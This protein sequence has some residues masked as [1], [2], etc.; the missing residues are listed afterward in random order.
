[1]DTPHRVRLRFVPVASFT[2]VM[3]L[4]GLSLAWTAAEATLGMRADVG[5]PLLYFATAVFVALLG[6]YAGKSALHPRRVADEFR[7]PASMSLFP[8]ISIGFILIAAGFA[9][10]HPEAA[11]VLWLGGAALHLGLTLFAVASWIDHHVYAVTQINPTWFIPVVGNILVPV[12]GVPGVS[13]EVS[14]FFF[15]VGLVFWLILATIIFYRMI[16]HDPLPSRLVPTLFILVAPPAVGFISYT[17]ITGT[18]DTFARVLYYVAAFTV[19][20]VATQFPKFLRVPFSLSWWA[21]SFPMAAFTI[22]TV[23]VYGYTQMAF[24][25]VLALVLLALLSILLAMLLART[26]M[27]LGRREI[28]V[29]GG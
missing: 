3:G 9:R 23:R 2:I 14:W 7:D 22:A 8:A 29:E 28:F 25:R 18:F 19:L 13:L 4:G 21:Y 5:R 20:I 16:F 10:S 17:T 24:F 12:A 15:S 26:I 6:V 27:A 1:M 11:R